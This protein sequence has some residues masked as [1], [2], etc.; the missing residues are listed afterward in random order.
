M[1]STNGAMVAQYQYDPF[2]NIEWMSGPLA[3]VNRYRFSSKEWNDTAGLYYYGFRFYDPNLQRWPNR[4]PIE[5]E[6]GINLYDYVNNAPMNFVDLNGLCGGQPGGPINFP[7]TGTGESGTGNGKAVSDASVNNA[8]LP[9]YNNIANSDNSNFGPFDLVNFLLGQTDT[10][11]HPNTYT[12]YTY[13]GIEYPTLYGMT[14][15]GR[16]LNYIGLGAG[17][18][19]NGFQPNAAW[20]ATYGY[21][22]Y[23]HPGVDPVKALA[24]MQAGYQAYQNMIADCPDST[25]SNVNNIAP[26]FVP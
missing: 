4:D 10:S 17:L 26:P 8:L 11:F 3:S 2:G 18:A 7:N 19:A 24:A 14:L 5:E 22:R 9:V 12:P 16:D 20:L 15:T 25:L 23:Q 13:T 6:G 1:V 21:Y